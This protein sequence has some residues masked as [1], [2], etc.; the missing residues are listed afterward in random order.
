MKLWLAFLWIFGVPWWWKVGCVCEGGGGG[1]TN[2]SIWWSIR[3]FIY[4]ELSL[5]N[6]ANILYIQHACRNRSVYWH[7]WRL[8]TYT[9]ILYTYITRLS[10]YSCFYSRLKCLPKAYF[11]NTPHKNIITESQEVFF[12]QR[13]KEQRPWSINIATC[14]K[15]GSMVHEYSWEN[16]MASMLVVVYIIQLILHHISP[17]G[18]SSHW[19]VTED[20]RIQAQVHTLHLNL[21]YSII[22]TDIWLSINGVDTDVG[23]QQYMREQRSIIISICCSH[24]I[25]E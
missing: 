19:V 12:I 13:V 14:R 7:I 21:D 2:N 4:H 17:S 8:F 25:L 20:G 23:W 22:L 24:V 5:S 18:G 11:T 1:R 9:C 15:T 3:F 16:N 6:H 10:S